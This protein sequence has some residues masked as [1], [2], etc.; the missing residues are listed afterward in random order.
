MPELVIGVGICDNCR[1]IVVVVVL[2]FVCLFKDTVSVSDYTV[3][4]GRM[5]ADNE[6]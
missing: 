4:N 2:C 1:I 3:S 6:W 5:T